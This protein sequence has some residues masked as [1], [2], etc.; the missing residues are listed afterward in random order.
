[1]YGLINT[2]MVLYLLYLYTAITHKAIDY[3]IILEMIR[4]VSTFSNRNIHLF[5]FKNII[6]L[7]HY[8]R[9]AHEGISVV[10]R[11][12]QINIYGLYLV[13]C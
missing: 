9:G 4:V 1:M 3:H 5:I 13:P 10:I 11:V 12:R 7:H 2:Y 6:F 8:G